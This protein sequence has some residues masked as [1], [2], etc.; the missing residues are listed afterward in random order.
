MAS[1]SYSVSTHSHPKV[2]AHNVAQYPFN[3]LVSTHSHPKVAAHN[4]AKYPFNIL[5][6][7]HSHP[8]VAATFGGLPLF[9]KRFTF[10][11]TATRRWLQVLP[12]PGSPVINVSTHS[13]PK[14]AADVQ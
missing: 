1:Q 8:K 7:T 5:V 4:V 2:A 14:V 6:S 12:M 11:H 10:Q 3:I 13:H 9:F